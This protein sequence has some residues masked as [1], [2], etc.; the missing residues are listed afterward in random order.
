[1]RWTAA[2]LAGWAGLLGVSTA[3]SLLPVSFWLDVR[4]IR[5]ESGAHDCPPMTVDRDLHRVFRAEW[6]VTI[7]Q[8]AEGGFSTFRTYSGAND[9]RPGN[10]LPPDLNL[11]WWTWQD[12]LSLPPARYRVHT[13]WKLTF[14]GGME[15]EI[16]R[17]SNVFEVTE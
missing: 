12:S 15:R 17:T 2:I 11:C 16:R 1:M 4:D 8:G 3:Q 7:M 13:Y 5:V 10:D 14:P 6:I 9:Y